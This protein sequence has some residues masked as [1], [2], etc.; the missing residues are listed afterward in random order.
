M[1]K[2]CFYVDED[3]EV[4]FKMIIFLEDSDDEDDEMGFVSIK[5]ESPK[6]KKLE[7]KK[8]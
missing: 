1:S 4:D 7:K 8:H 5:E 3:G 2:D 6:K